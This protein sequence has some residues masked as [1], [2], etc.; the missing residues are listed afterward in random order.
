M[1]RLRTRAAP[2]AIAALVGAIAALGASS[3]LGCDEARERA[4]ATPGAPVSFGNAGPSAAPEQPCDDGASRACHVDLG[5]K[6]GVRSCA[7]G[8]QTCDAGRWGSCRGSFSGHVDDPSLTTW[9]SGG[10]STKSLS[11]PKPCAGNP[12][13]PGCVA[14]SEVPD[15]GLAP[16]STSG[17]TWSGGLVD[18]LPSGFQNKGLKDADHPPTKTPCAGVEDCQFDHRC[19]AGKCVPWGPGQTDPSCAGV[20]LTAGP[21]CSG[22][23]PV[24]NRG[25][26]TAPPGIEILVLSGNSQQMQDNLGLCGGF[27]SS[28]RSS[29]ATTEPIPP[30]ACISVTGCALGGTKSIVVN[31]P[32]PPGSKPPIAECHCG[33]DWTVYHN[34]G[35]CSSRTREVHAKTTHRETYV[36]TCGS[37]TRPRWQFLTWNAEL[38]SNASGAARLGV[39]AHT[40]ISPA[41]PTSDCSDC[42]VIG[43]APAVDPAECHAGGPGGCPKDLGA[44]L[45]PRAADDVLELVLDLDPSPDLA[46]APRLHRWE[47]TFTCVPTE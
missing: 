13:D 3:T 37:G 12:C 16:T 10:I 36:A 20:D 43:D 9:S 19:D 47:V 41:V 44:A 22:T 6:D 31:P 27:H 46:L 2:A 23:I 17:G 42:V 26:T 21:T 33:N 29:C 1:A 39:R 14:F 35:S 34:G 38:P 40:A 24:C 5:V 32:S 8:T 28:G 11:A 45:G 4:A 15:G 7:H 30:G 25:N 18:Q